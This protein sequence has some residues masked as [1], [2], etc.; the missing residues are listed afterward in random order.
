[1]WLQYNIYDKIKH[2]KLNNNK[3]YIIYMNLNFLNPMSS[4]S[5]LNPMGSNSFLNPLN[6][7]N[8]AKPKPSSKPS[9]P[10]PKPSPKP[11]IPILKPL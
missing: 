8:L 7:I 1:M 11:S 5:F 6:I 4:N 3:T 9:K 2:N 10:S